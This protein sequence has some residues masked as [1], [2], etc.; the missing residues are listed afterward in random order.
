MSARVEGNS[1][2]RRH[3]SP[4]T[5]GWLTSTARGGFDVRLGDDL[6]GR[7]RGRSVALD[8]STGAQPHRGRRGRML[9]NR[10]IQLTVDAGRNGRR[11]DA[12]GRRARDHTQ[13]RRPNDVTSSPTLT[14][15]DHGSPT[16]AWTWRVGFSMASRPPAQRRYRCPHHRA[17]RLTANLTGPDP[18]PLGTD[19]GG[20]RGAESATS[21]CRASQT[22]SDAHERRGRA[23]VWAFV[24]RFQRQRATGSTSST[25]SRAGQMSIAEVAGGTTATE[26]GVRSLT[27][28][29]RGSRTSTTGQG[30]Q[31]RCRQRG[32]DHRACP[33]PPRDLDF[34]RDAEGCAS[35]S[36][37]TSPGPR[38]SRTCST[39]ST[40]RRSAVGGRRAGGIPGSSLVDGNGIAL[41]DDGTVGAGATSVTA[42]NGSFAAE[43]PGHPRSTTGGASLD[44][45]GPRNWLP[46]TASS[47]T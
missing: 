40:P 41:V 13:R 37:W 33:I 32:P 39:R 14:G 7:G 23:L 24:W 6:R 4:S 28:R 44:R 3:A 26:L 21:T 11:S 45:R 31:I 46:S 29:P 9:A 20:Q 43:R 12:A 47:P 27:V 19:P 34:P 22:F 42:L 17:R 38:P 30:V 18:V 1:R 2:S 36:T 25:S 35:S 5:R 15:G 10:A 8:L 16:W